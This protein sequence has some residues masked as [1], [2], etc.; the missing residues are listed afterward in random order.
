MRGSPKLPRIV[1]KDV[2]RA[3]AT[4]LERFHPEPEPRPGINPTAVL[5]KCV[6][7][8]VDVSNGPDAVLVDSVHVGARTPI[9]RFGRFL[10]CR[11]CGSRR[12]GRRSR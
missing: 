12:S 5:G 11:P 10:R 1:V 7:L 4:L 3:L 2:H 8:G 6:G 9:G